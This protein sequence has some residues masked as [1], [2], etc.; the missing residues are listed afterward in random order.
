MEVERQRMYEDLRAELKR[1]VAKAIWEEMSQ[2]PQSGS[3]DRFFSKGT[4]KVASTLYKPTIGSMMKDQQI[5]NRNKISIETLQAVRESPP[6]VAEE[7]PRTYD[8]QG[9]WK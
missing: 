2:L 4:R 7:T 1:N 9:P 5:A 6:T 8:T 3:P